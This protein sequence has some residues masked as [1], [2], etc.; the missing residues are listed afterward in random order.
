MIEQKYGKYNTTKCSRRL[1]TY[2]IYIS[3]IIQTFIDILTQDIAHS[4]MSTSKA[5]STK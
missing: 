3:K 1:Q 4:I 2:S 5:N